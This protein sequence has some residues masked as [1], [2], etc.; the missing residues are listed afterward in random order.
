MPDL[1]GVYCKEYF[2]TVRLLTSLW[3]VC[4][5]VQKAPRRPF[6]RQLFDC[7]IPL[8]RIKLYEKLHAS[9]AAISAFNTPKSIVNMSNDTI[10]DAMAYTTTTEQWPTAAVVGLASLIALIV[11]SVA[12]F[13]INICK[14]H[15]SPSFMSTRLMGSLDLARTSGRTR[16]NAAE[17]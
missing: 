2:L 9:F 5:L 13:V 6:R 3:I 1:I 11:F 10:Q 12:G 8:Q 7:L 14:Y 15:F 4:V 17:P 16:L